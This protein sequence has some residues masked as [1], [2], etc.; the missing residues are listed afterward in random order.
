[1][2]YITFLPRDVRL[3]LLGSSNTHKHDEYYGWN[4]EGQPS[5]NVLPSILI[6]NF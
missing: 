2:L 1:M 3:A 6:P 5:A 4:T